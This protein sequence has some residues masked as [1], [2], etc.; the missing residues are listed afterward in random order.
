VTAEQQT[1][2]QTLITEVYAPVFFN[3]LASYGIVPTTEAERAALLEIA[4]GIDSPAVQPV[5]QAAQ[6][7][8][9]I[10][11]AAGGLRTVRQQAGDPHFA[12]VAASRIKEAASGLIAD[13]RVARAAV[14]WA[15]AQ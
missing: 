2:Y 5:K 1:A 15:S 14:L 4:E 12:K 7:P 6:A 3:K 11:A 8:S 10:E 9:W 13:P